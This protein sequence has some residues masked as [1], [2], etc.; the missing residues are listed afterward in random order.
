MFV[1]FTNSQELVEI[2]KDQL[3]QLVVSVLEL[4]QVPSV[5]TSIHFVDTDDISRLHE[6]YFDDPSPTDCI[7]FPIDSKD[8]DTPNKVLGEIFVCPEVAHEYSQKH[9]VDFGE[10]LSLYVVHGLLHLLGY[11]DIE[12]DDQKIMREEEAKCMNHL[13]SLSLILTP[14]IKNPSI[15]KN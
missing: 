4:N 3:E 6:E 12:E 5:E 2:S 13:K 14:K 1:H 9:A 8:E 11:D 15:C 10:E 7:S